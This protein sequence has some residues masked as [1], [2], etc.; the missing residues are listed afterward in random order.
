MFRFAL[1]ATK[2]TIPTKINVV[3]PRFMATYKTSTGLVGLAVDPNGR[4]TL[5]DISVKVLNTVKVNYFYIVKL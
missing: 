4:D 1:A 5:I 3:T 2:K